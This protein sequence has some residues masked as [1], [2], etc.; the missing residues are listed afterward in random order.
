MHALAVITNDFVND[1]PVD[2]CKQGKICAHAYIQAG[3]DVGA[4][5]ADKDIARSDDLTAI[6]FYTQAL[7]LTIKVGGQAVL[8]RQL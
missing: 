3:F 8:G 7:S 5:L 4:M 1:N 2:L 6:L